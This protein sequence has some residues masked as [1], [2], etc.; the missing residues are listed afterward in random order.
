[1]NAGH[2]DL[3]RIGDQSRPALFDLDIQR[4]TPLHACVIETAARLDADGGE[5]AAVD[6]AALRVALE[7]ARA[8]GCEALAIALLHATRS[9]AHERRIAEL[10]RAAGFAH[11]ICSHE[12]SALPG[13]LERARTAL[14]EA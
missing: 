10:A 3:L 5:L 2:G 7:A 4:S 13:L 6:E 11:V 8:D 12:V 9:P 1:L 14:V